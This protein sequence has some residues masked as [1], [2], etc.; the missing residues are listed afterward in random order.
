MTGVQTCA[1]PISSNGTRTFLAKASGNTLNA[2]GT[3]A[4]I[5]YAI[6]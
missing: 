4:K 5:T 6:N 1:L 3:S 2:G